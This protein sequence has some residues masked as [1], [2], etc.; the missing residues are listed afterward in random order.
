MFSCEKLA[1]HFI[2]I[3]LTLHINRD[4]KDLEEEELDYLKFIKINSSSSPKI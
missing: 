4:I 3:V 1:S 2:P